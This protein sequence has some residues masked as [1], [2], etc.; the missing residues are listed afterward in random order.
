MNTI[1][2]ILV[3]LSSKIN[4]FERKNIDVSKSSVGWHLE[5]SLKTIDQIITAC[6]KSDPST[7]QWKF[8]LNRFLIMDVLQKI[9]RGKAKAPKVVQPEGDISKESLQMHLDKVYQNLENWEDVHENCCFFHP[10]FG[11]LNKKA[12]EKFLVLHTNHHLKIIE[13]ICN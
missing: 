8:K 13:D 11:N 7:Y 12:T 1:N 5:H 9:P 2:P 10:F 6:K 4:D 3:I